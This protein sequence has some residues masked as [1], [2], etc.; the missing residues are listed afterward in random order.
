MK[1]NKLM[2]QIKKF[3]LTVIRSNSQ[4]RKAKTILREI[5]FDDDLSAYV[6]ILVLLIS[7]YEVRKY[8]QYF[9]E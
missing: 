8:K 6:D 3:P 1:N 9:R 5:L 2:K 7:E 4:H